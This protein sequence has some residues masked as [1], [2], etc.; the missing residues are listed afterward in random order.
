MRI[1]G[2]LSQSRRDFT[3]LMGCEGCGATEKLTT[4]YDDRYYHDEVIPA[5]V[6]KACGESRNSLGMTAAKTATRY[7]AGEVV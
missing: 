5:M 1:C 3:A 4:G 2:I 7:A 6:C